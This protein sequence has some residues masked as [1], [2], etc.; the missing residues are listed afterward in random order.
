[1]NLDELANYLSAGFSDPV[2]QQLAAVLLDWKADTSTAQDLRESVERYIGNTSIRREEDHK[3]VYDTWSSFRD[4]AID[5][6]GGLTMNER[7]YWFGLFDRFDSSA[8]EEKLIIYR[9]LHARP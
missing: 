4:N 2:V 6:I 9:K 5:G 7:L 3:K 1:M 8:N